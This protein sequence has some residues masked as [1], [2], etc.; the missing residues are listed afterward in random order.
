MTVHRVTQPL[1]SSSG[2]SDETVSMIFVDAHATPQMQPKLD[3]SEDL[4]VVQLDF[5]G[6]CRLMED[7][8]ARIEARAWLVLYSY[9]LLGRLP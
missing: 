3:L 6:V 5:A 9:Q 7:C 2:L 8:S 1:Y 4:Q